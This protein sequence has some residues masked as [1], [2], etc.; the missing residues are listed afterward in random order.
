MAALAGLDTKIVDVESYAVERVFQLI[1]D[2]LPSQPEHVALID[3]GHSQTTLYVVAKDGDL[4][5]VV[6]S[7]LVARS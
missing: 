5:I 3:I 1:V 2:S 7:F 4:F 6:S